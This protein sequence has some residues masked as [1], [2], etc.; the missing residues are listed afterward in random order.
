MFSPCVW[1]STVEWPIHVTRIAPPM[2]RAG[3]FVWATGTFFGQG[4]RSSPI[5]N[6]MNIGP[7]GEPIFWCPAMPSGLKNRC[8]SK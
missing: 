6:R 5:R 7:C 2:T 1:T 8:P 3:G 4:A